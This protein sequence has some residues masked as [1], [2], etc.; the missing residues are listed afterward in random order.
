MSVVITSAF[1]NTLTPRQIEELVAGDGRWQ[2]DINGLLAVD[3][4]AEARG[5]T[6][7]DPDLRKA[8]LE[9]CVAVADELRSR[10]AAAERGYEASVFSRIRVARY[11][12]GSMDSVA[13]FALGL[14]HG[15]F[16]S[17]Q[18][19]ARSRASGDLDPERGVPSYI[20]HRAGI[21]VCA[22]IC[23]VYFKIEDSATVGELEGWLDVA[24]GLRPE[25]RQLAKWA[26]HR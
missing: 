9:V 2:L 23:G 22:A 3:S 19:F 5:M 1:L 7:Q 21:A 20:G 10:P 25:N 14:L 13:L 6:A 15:L 18:A 8:Y 4:H 26:A 12:G 16:S 24:V 11:C 17:A